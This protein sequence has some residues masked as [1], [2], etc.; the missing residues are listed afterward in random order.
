MRSVRN[1]E[2][3]RD[4]ERSPQRQRLTTVGPVHAD[5][6]AAPAA[7]T[8][9]LGRTVI[10]QSLG[11]QP[12]IV[13]PSEKTGESGLLQRQSAWQTHV[14]SCCAART[15]QL[16]RRPTTAHTFYLVVV[17]YV[18]MHNLTTNHARQNGEMEQL[19][20]TTAK[21]RSEGPTKVSGHQVA[22][23]M[24]DYVGVLTASVTGLTGV[25]GLSREW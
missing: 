11:E 2:K 12:A 9:R 22:C 25:T 8:P 18:C 1:D 19:V 13:S 10:C 16:Q 14:P 20:C 6:R 24:C 3:G 7:H 15:E 23:S 17:Q 5:A 4:D 21:L